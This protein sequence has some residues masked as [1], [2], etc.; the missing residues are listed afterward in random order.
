MNLYKKV[1]CFMIRHF[2]TKNKI[3]RKK[4]LNLFE[5]QLINGV[6]TIL[7]Y[8]LKW[9]L[10]KETKQR[11]GFLHKFHCEKGNRKSIQ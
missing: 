11:L 9:L 8:N 1:I 6:N 4:T 3:I 10:Y 5:R 2:D 7:L